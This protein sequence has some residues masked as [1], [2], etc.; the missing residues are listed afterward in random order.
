MKAYV[1]VTDTDW[2]RHLSGFDELD[3]ANFWTPNPWGGS[4]G[5]LDRGQPLLFKL[6]AP[7][8][9]IVGGGFFE[10]YTQLPIGLAWDAFGEKNGVGSYRELQERIARLRQEPVDPWSTELTI[11]CILLLEPFFFERDRWIPQLEDWKPQTQ[12]GKGYDLTTDPGRELWEQV[13]RRL[14]S[15]PHD[16]ERP[17]GRERQSELEVGGG[18]EESSGRPRRVGQGIFR[19][20]ITDLYDR[21]C[22]IT[23][24]KALPTLDAAHIRPN[25]EEPEHYVRNGMLLRSDVHRMFD[26]GYLIV[27]PDYEVE[28][29]RRVRSDFDDGENYLMLDG[30]KVRVPKAPDHRPDPDSLLWHRENQF[31]GD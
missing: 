3:E 2:Y 12:R 18:Y 16:S 15:K 31:R 23:R 24:E 7:H 20:V 4:F 9:A 25:S 1:A 10:H 19:T 6:K 27:T 28:V 21:Q 13:S 14:Q 26:A 22:A 30:E 8:N 11:G 5:V 29:S 17:L